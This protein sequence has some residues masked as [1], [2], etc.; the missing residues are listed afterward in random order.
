MTSHRSYQRHRCL[1]FLVMRVCRDVVGSS[2]TGLTQAFLRSCFPQKHHFSS[3][4]TN[5]SR[6]F[7]SLNRSRSALQALTRA[8]FWASV[9]FFGTNLPFFNVFPI[10]CIRL[11]TA[12]CV[13]PNSRAISF[14][15]MNGY[16]SRNSS[17]SAS[18]KLSSCLAPIPCWSSREKS[19]S[20][21]LAYHRFIVAIP[22][23]PS[24]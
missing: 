1:F 10:L 16:S 7:R 11:D 19:S 21:N 23:F 15:V 13:T 4:T 6:K 8:C 2:C 5:S 18:S 17:T 22:I 9:R 3:A 20:L 12:C 24:P 14:C